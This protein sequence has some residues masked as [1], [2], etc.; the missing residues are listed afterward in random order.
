MPTKKCHWPSS[1][2]RIESLATAVADL[3]HVLKGVQGGDLEWG[4]LC[5][6]KTGRTGLQIVRY[7]QKKLSYEPG[8][9]HLPILRKALKPWTKISAPR[10]YQQPSTKRCAWL[11]RPPLPKSQIYWSPC[12]PLWNSFSEL[13]E[14]L[15]PGLQSLVRN[16]INQTHRFYVVHF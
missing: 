4:S 8:F 13:S 11:H 12:F 9:L 5:S 15:S 14:R 6:G 10:D 7:F 1:S 2:T 16:W 3:Q